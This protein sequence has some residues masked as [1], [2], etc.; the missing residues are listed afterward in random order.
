MEVSG[1]YG[2]S[3]LPMARRERAATGAPY[4]PVAS[5]SRRPVSITS[6]RSEL[7]HGLPGSGP[8]GEP[9]DGKAGL[10]GESG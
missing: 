9:H 1:G 6:P 4:W 8:G 5:A 10:F 2:S 3:A 7:R